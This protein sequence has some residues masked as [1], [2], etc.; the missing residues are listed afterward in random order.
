MALWYLISR[1]LDIWTEWRK[2][3]ICNNVHNY[4]MGSRPLRVIEIED[5]VQ[6]LTLHSRLDP[7]NP[8]E[9]LIE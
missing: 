5:L 9:I 4:N 6:T 1:N 8:C 2:R 3:Y 7:D